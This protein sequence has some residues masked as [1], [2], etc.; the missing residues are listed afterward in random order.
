MDKIKWLYLYER[1]ISNTGFSY[2][3]NITHIKEYWEKILSR[4]VVK[5]IEKM[6][7]ENLE[8][9]LNTG[10]ADLKDKQIIKEIENFE[11]DFFITCEMHKIH[12]VHTWKKKLLFGNF[13]IHFMKY[14]I[15][16]TDGKLCQKLAECYI[17]SMVTKLYKLSMSTLMFEMYLEK[18]I[19]SLKG[20][21][22]EEEYDY[23]NEAYLSDK[24]YVKKIFKL[25]PCLE[26]MI[27]AS[28]QD[29][30][31]EYLNLAGRLETDHADIVEKLCDS[32]EFTSIIG[33]QSRITDPYE[34]GKAAAIITLDNGYKIVYKT[35]SLKNE[36]SYQTYLHFLSKNCTYP[37]KGYAMIDR[38]CY[39]WEE[40]VP[41]KE[42]RSPDEIKRY[43]YRYG[44]LIFSNYILNKKDL[45]FENLV[46]CGEYPMVI[47]AQTIISN[48]RK[49]PNRSARD[50]IY[51]LLRNSILASGLL[52]YDRIEK[53]GEGYPIAVP[54]IK[55]MFTSNMRFTYL[56][57]NTLESRNT[58]TLNGS[59]VDA[60]NFIE[61][62]HTGFAD[63]YKN[64]LKNKKEAIEKLTLF[65]NRKVRYFIQ[66]SNR[67]AMLL[68]TS[69]H[70]DFLHDPRD[71]ELLLCSVFE[72]Y[73]KVQGDIQ[74][75]KAEIRDMLG[76][77]IPYFYTDTSKRDLY[78]SSG[79]AIKQYFGKTG[80]ELV[81]EKILALNGKDLS[82]QSMYLKIALKTLKDLKVNKKKMNAD[83]L[84]TKKVL[85]D[86]K[87]YKEA[88]KHVA[89]AL[90]QDA[91]FG[92]RK[93]DINW[94]GLFS[95]HS[96]QKAGWEVRPLGTDLYEG[97]SGIAIFFHAL[98]Q[99]FPDNR[100]KEVCDCIKTE[101][102]QYTDEMAVK[103]IEFQEVS[104]GVFCGEASLVYA[105][106]V[107]HQLT[108]QDQYLDYAKKQFEVL[109]KVWEGDP[110]YDVIYG[111]A[112]AL[113][114]I[115]N[116]YE[117]TKE[118][119]YLAEAKKIG[120]YLVRHQEKNGGWSKKSKKREL[121][122]FFRGAA[123][124]S[125][126]LIKLWGITKQMHYVKAGLRGIGHEARLSA[127]HH[128]AAGILLS[129]IKCHDIFEG[130]NKKKLEDDMKDALKTI[131][132]QG[133]LNNNSL[134]HGNLKNVEI[135]SEYLKIKNDSEIKKLYTHILDLVSQNI[136]KDKY[137]CEKTSLYE[138]HIP[139]F[140]TGLSGMGYSILRYLN[141]KLP[142]I[143]AVEI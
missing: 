43:F 140:M 95:D 118:E 42:C 25:Y 127:W 135:L 63:A 38:G 59:P 128:S 28:I 37:L 23:Y 1:K 17:E 85:N 58:V 55:G 142:C 75:V 123:G 115:L 52:P 117:I 41:Q 62:I 6:Y 93:E 121:A 91:I 21:T 35:H 77:E 129:R 87:Q 32:K 136:C 89:D 56:Y 3:E 20:E 88:V 116:L 5:D 134:Y 61:Y 143:L 125:Y 7:E 4:Q 16:L 2:R 96:D 98:H 19:N 106:V 26:R 27:Y 15:Y 103:E 131:C 94:K 11:K 83:M 31:R 76:M 80:L 141:P 47:D 22:P 53:S 130:E 84:M 137:D 99:T 122:G 81:K 101:L 102:F 120:D 34:K 90:L 110:Y 79:Y 12:K 51:D 133:F 112:G 71:R 29:I 30:T 86:P 100:Y 105:Y 39:G 64:V 9:L 111:S 132:T 24:K 44:L 72:N 74:V 48:H 40:F 124:I 14:G 45:H 73:E 107:I 139:G 65:H 104:S 108:K 97:L 113:L 109:K 70:P 46:S 49:N 68:H 92:D 10:N 18:E 66:H 33:I 54:V 67:Y 36:A 50:K 82:D 138:H 69:C 8:N 13:F 60:S 114:A 78:T 119:K 57:S 126:A